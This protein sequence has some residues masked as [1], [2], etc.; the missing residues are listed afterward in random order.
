M[1]NGWENRIALHSACMY[2]ASFNVMKMLID[3]G[4]GKGLVMAKDSHGGTALHYL[5]DYIN[6]HDS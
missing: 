2:V 4:G 3:A 5:C 6:K 1:V